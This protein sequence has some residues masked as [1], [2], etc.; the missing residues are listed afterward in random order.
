VASQSLTSQIEY[1]VDDEYPYALG[2][3]SLQRDML[4]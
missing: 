1:L 3:T 4:L 2:G